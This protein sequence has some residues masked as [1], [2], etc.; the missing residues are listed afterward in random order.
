LV[1]LRKAD[2]AL[3]DLLATL[4]HTELAFARLYRDLRIAGQRCVSCLTRIECQGTRWQCYRTS[5]FER[6]AWEPDLRTVVIADG[7]A[8]AYLALCLEQREADRNG[9]VGLE[10]DRL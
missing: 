3:A 8:A 5:G 10:D 1:V 4:E 7:S 2:G 6:S 9:R